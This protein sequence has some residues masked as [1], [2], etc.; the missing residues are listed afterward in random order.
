M[1]SREKLENITSK[2]ID[3][4]TL[5]GKKVPVKVVSI[6][7]G[8]TCDV[9]FELYSQ[10]KERLKCRMLNYDRPELKKRTNGKLAR[11]YLANLVV[12]GDPEDTPPLILKSY[13]TEEQLQ[14]ELDK[15][16]DLTY[17]E[18]RKFDSFERALVTLKRNYDDKESTNDM[19]KQYIEELKRRQT[20]RIIL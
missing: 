18:L 14:E 19:M 8:D 13:M 16:K 6:H 10:Y 11:D 1:S 2:D 3:R 12:G 15:N 9:V 5:D 7:D 20:N 4:F 17:A